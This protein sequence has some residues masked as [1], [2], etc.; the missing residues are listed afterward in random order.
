MAGL[1]AGALK[2]VGGHLLAKKLF[3][4]S[5]KKRRAEAE[6]FAGERREKRKGRRKKRLAERDSDAV[7]QGTTTPVSTLMSAGR[8]RGG[9]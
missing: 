1:A 3:G 8:G 2:F 7:Y 9:Y 6:E 5:K 4:K